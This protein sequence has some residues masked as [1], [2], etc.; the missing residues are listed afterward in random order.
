[1]LDGRDIVL[2]PVAW[3]LVPLPPPTTLSFCIWAD[4][5]DG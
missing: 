4:A 5:K 2:L 3:A 1:M